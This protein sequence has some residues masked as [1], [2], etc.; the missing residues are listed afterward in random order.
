MLEIKLDAIEQ[1]GYICTSKRN[2]K[3]FYRYYVNK[4]KFWKPHIIIA[5]YTIEDDGKGGTIV[6]KGD[7]NAKYCYMTWAELQACAKVIADVE[8]EAA[9]VQK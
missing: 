4:Q 6:Y 2:G 8:A 5:R 9:E 7:D 1:L 3:S